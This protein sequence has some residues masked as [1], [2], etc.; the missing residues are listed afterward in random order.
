[1]DTDPPIVSEILGNKQANTWV[2][3]KVV[4]KNKLEWTRELPNVSLTMTNE[5]YPA[6]FDF[7]GNYCTNLFLF[8]TTSICYISNIY[9]Y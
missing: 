3:M 9:I 7:K 4:E 5:P 2:N 6:R 8:Y 1:M